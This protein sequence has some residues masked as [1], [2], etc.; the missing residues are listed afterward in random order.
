ME[1]RVVSK[2]QRKYIFPIV[3]FIFPENLPIV[4]DYYGKLLKNL[5]AVMIKAWLSYVGLVHL[6]T[7]DH[8]DQ[9]NKPSVMSHSARLE[10]HT[11]FIVAKSQITDHSLLEQ[12]TS[13]FSEQTMA[14]F[15]VKIDILKV[16]KVLYICDFCAPTF[17]IGVL[18]NPQRIHVPNFVEI[19]QLELSQHTISIGLADN[20]V[21]TGIST[22]SIYNIVE[23]HSQYQGPNMM[24]KKCVHAAIL[25]LLRDNLNT[26]F[27]Q[28]T[29]PSRNVTLIEFPSLINGN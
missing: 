15:L 20:I 10:S 12:I 4:N 22:H 29:L 7:F 28:S 14:A 19:M 13:G 23:R 2:Y 18:L 26:T 25:L 17:F 21:F 9:D 6:V 5:N 11:L 3:Y 27:L 1:K 8:Y 16:E 24:C